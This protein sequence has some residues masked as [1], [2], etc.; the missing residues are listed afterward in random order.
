MPT[1]SR[2]TEAPLLAGRR[3]T[4]VPDTVDFRDAMFT[5]TLVEV[6]VERPLEL[7]LDTMN[8]GLKI[9]DQG[10]EGACTGFA[11]AAIANYLLWTGQ[12]FRGER[13]PDR[14]S[15]W[16]LYRMAQRY[17]EWPGEGY[18]GSSARG[19]MKAWHKHGVCSDEHWCQ[20]DDSDQNPQLW[21]RRWQDAVR[22]PLG[23]YYRV[24]HKDFVAMHSA[25]SEVG[26]LYATGTV[27]TGWNPS[28][29]RDGHIDYEDDAT[30]GHAFAIVGYDQDGF[31]IQNSWGQSWG[32]G[33]CAR[34][35]YDD[36]LRNGFDVWVARLGAPIRIQR[37]ATAASGIMAAAGG[38]RSY[39][40]SDLRGHIISVGNDGLPRT[41]GTYGTDAAEIEAIFAEEVPAYVDGYRQQNPGAAV[42]LLLYAH[43][44]L[45]GEQAAIQRVAEYRSAL[46]ER[47]VYPVAFSWK[48]D[49]WTTVTNLLR[50][51]LRQR[52]P[53]GILDGARDFLLDRLDD[54]LEPLARSLGGKGQWDEMKENGMLATTSRHGAARVAAHAL[55]RHLGDRIGA[56]AGDD[57]IYLH[58]IGHSAGSIFL[59][60]LAR[61][62]ASDGRVDFGDLQ[63][64]PSV[65]RAEGVGSSIDSLSLW[66]P[67]CTTELFRAAYK[68]LIDDG[69][70]GRFTLFTLTDEAEQDDHCANVYHKSLLY[71]VANAFEKEPRIPLLRPR[72]I[73]VLGMSTFVDEEFAEYFVREARADWIRSP[74]ESRLGDPNASH[75]T[76]HGGFDDDG[77]T[78]Q[79]TLARMLACAAARPSEME[80]AALTE[81]RFQRSGQRRR[82]IRHELDEQSRSMT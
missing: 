35:T 72:G 71:L 50:D 46:M 10:Q 79:A 13:D 30:G 34:L 11:L 78:V 47:G 48:T 59:A 8:E 18:S 25:I 51:A 52:R 63:V 75:S 60:P 81:F 22:R 28:A 26:I 36:W 42:H 67:A 24:N 3:L 69:R 62:L 31:W 82:D 45:V 74:N 57:R 21:P 56:G 14:T 12:R 49:F 20:G 29:V 55:A 15:P 53:E 77:A 38:T 68:P 4:A 76:S 41:S 9:L 32:K 58:M 40:F 54:S 6:P 73:P 19:A 37:E 16:M 65:T 80:P 43:G 33:G 1:R 61:L 7:Y 66:A 17:D 27:H 64:H 23:A 70:I 5:P 2:T 39:V 44:G